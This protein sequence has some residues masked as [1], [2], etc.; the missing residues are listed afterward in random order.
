MLQD[1]TA[2]WHT[3]IND[4]VTIAPTDT[5]TGKLSS[6]TLSKFAVKFF[7]GMLTIKSELMVK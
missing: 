6:S 7:E 3:D 5:D 1:M 2:K 4:K